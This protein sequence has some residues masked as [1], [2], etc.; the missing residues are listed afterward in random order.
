MFQ[1]PLLGSIVQQD[2]VGFIFIADRSSNRVRR[3]NPAGIISTFAGNGRY[4]GEWTYMSLP[5]PKVELSEL[6]DNGPATLASLEYP[7]DVKGDK[8]GNIFIAEFT[9]CRVRMISSNIITTI[10]GSDKCRYATYD[11]QFRPTDIVSSVRS[12]WVVNKDTFYFS[13]G[14]RLTL[15]TTIKQSEEE[16][17]GDFK[18]QL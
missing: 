5:D 7:Y 17:K 11:V 14:G 6:G 3:V 1:L 13:E 18:E 9:G 2:S 10:I 16:K 15:A 12:L 4:A 8:E